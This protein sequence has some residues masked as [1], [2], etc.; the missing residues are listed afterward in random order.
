MH[1]SSNKQ[2]F[3]RSIKKVC[4]EYQSPWRFLSLKKNNRE[5][6][7]IGCV[8]QIMA[9]CPQSA[10][11]AHSRSPPKNPKNGCAPVPLKHSNLLDPFGRINQQ[12]KVSNAR[13]KFMGPVGA[14]AFTGHKMR[15][16][17][18]LRLLYKNNMQRSFLE[19]LLS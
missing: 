7:V 9:S 16:P 13:L 19:K 8:G 1:A 14:E 4:V 18:H 12:L 3:T 6:S 5:R 11:E 2:Q 15:Y 10:E 17:E